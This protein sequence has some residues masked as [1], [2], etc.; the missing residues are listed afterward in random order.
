MRVKRAVFA[1]KIHAHRPG[2]RER[3]A[4]ELLIL[5]GQ[6]FSQISQVN[7]CCKSELI[8]KV[9]KN[10]KGGEGQTCEV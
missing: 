2:A 10:S 3:R 8:C 1:R 6:D 9:L 4:H 7:N 5:S